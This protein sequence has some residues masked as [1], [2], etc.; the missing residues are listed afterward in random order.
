MGLG[1]IKQSHDCYKGFL[2]ETIPQTGK[3]S[4]KIENFWTEI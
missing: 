1:E 3:K 2:L 4:I